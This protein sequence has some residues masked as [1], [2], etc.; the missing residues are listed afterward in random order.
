MKKIVKIITFYDDGTF[1]ES[2]PSQQP[3][4]PLPFPMQPYE[5][6]T[7]CSKC[8]LKLDQVMGYVCNNYPCP[9]GLG[10][11]WCGGGK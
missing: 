8:G 9:T 4:M 6:I 1:T 2:A 10:G 11:A 5:P 3:A 7:Q